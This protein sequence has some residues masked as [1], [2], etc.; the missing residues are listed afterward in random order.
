M[1]LGKSTRFIIKTQARIADYVKLWQTCKYWLFIWRTIYGNRYQIKK[2]KCTRGKWRKS[3]K[4]NMLIWFVSCG[5]LLNKKN[6]DFLGWHP[7]RFY[8]QKRGE[9]GLPLI[10]SIMLEC[11]LKNTWACELIQYHVIFLLETGPFY[12]P[13]GSFQNC[14]IF[15]G[16]IYAKDAIIRLSTHP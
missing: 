13:A 2:G 8:V 5:C 15:L 7:H 6:K 1:T 12:F 11:L 16:L 3:V 4:T 14:M 9:D 10:V